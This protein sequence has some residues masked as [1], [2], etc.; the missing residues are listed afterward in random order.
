MKISSL[1]LT[2]QATLAIIGALVGSGFLVGFLT[3]FGYGFMRGH[4][5]KPEPAAAM[6]VATAEPAALSADIVPESLKREAELPVENGGFDLAEHDLGEDEN[7]FYISGTVKNRSGRAFD[8][9]RVAFSLHDANGET[10][11]VIEDRTAD[12]MEDED[13]WGFV[14]YIPYTDIRSLDSYS[15]Q[16]IMGVRRQ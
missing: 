15:L 3:G 14:V 4:K 11:S 9:V 13:S 7:G 16:G 12:R 10:Y 5:A 1:R 6:E 8:S 2:R